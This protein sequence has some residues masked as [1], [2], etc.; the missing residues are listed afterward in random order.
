MKFLRPA[1][2][3]ALLSVTSAGV[4]FADDIHVIFD[5]PPTFQ[6]PNNTFNPV[7]PGGGAVSFVWGSCANDPFAPDAIA[8]DQA[9]ANFA[10]VSLTNAITQ[11]TFTFVA[12]DPDI[13][14]GAN[15]VAC[16]SIDPA[17][18]DPS[19][20]GGTFNPGDLVT[21]TFSGGT[22]IPPSGSKTQLSVF[23]LAENG[24]SADDINKL[25]WTVA[26]PEPS[27][28]TLLAAGMGLIGLCMV[29]AKR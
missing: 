9:C 17:L 6:D 3:V 2:L 19:C 16:D 10:N 15:T 26:A 13:I 4:T 29:F 22:A 14:P 5:P 25:N 23:F 8:N 18:S 11:L 27:Q 21:I 20:P 1:L 12:A 28:L 24:V 7:T